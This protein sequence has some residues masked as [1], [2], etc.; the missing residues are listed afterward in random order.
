MVLEIQS[1]HD[2]FS[3]IFSLGP[4]FYSVLKPGNQEGEGKL[5]NT[6]KSGKG[7]RGFWTN[8]F[9]ADVICEQ[10]LNQMVEIVFPLLDAFDF[11]YKS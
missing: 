4:L 11:L 3:S 8:R 5:D 1:F 6:K 7:G 2:L 9:S 10:P